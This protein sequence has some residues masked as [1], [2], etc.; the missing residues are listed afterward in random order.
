MEHKLKIFIFII[1]IQFSILFGEHKGIV[2]FY[3]F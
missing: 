2:D 1:C 3:K